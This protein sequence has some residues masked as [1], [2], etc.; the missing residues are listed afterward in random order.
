MISSILQEKFDLICADPFVLEFFPDLGIE[1]SFPDDPIFGDHDI[2]YIYL[3]DGFPCVSLTG[4]NAPL[5]RIDFIAIA[6]KYGC[7]F[8]CLQSSGFH[9]QGQVSSVPIVEPDYL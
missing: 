2:L 8:R 3:F 1:V 6:H 9:W 5:S 4:K 7:K